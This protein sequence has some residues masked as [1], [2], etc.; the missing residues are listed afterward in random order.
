MKALALKIF[1]LS[2]C[3]TLPTRAADETAA[4][5]AAKPPTEEMIRARQLERTQTKAKKASP[6]SPS[7]ATAPGSATPPAAPAPTPAATAASDAVNTAKTRAEPASVLPKV[8][9]NKTR[10][11]VLEHQLR[12]QEKEIDRERKNT[13]SGDMDRMLNNPKISIPILGGESTKYRTTVASER[14]SL[15]ESEKDIMEAIAHAKTKAEKAE[16]QKELTEI[17]ALRRD[18]EKSLR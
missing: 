13:K 8:E 14:I 12:E 15:M 10:I 16:L 17:K 9:V 4:V 5:P 6:P 1:V 7:A 18:L 2:T 11:T 3:L